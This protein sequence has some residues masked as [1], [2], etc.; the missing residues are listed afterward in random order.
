MNSLG[1][2][3]VAGAGSPTGSMSGEKDG[4]ACVFWCVQVRIIIFVAYIDTMYYTSHVFFFTAGSDDT[5]PILGLPRRCPSPPLPRLS[6]PLPLLQR[7]KPL[8]LDQV[9]FLTGVHHLGAAG[10]VGARARRREVLVARKTARLP[11]QLTR[12][13]TSPR[14]DTIN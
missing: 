2:L 5:V 6:R 14:L 10:K 7:M 12:P 13:R 3:V 1:P 11:G 8:Q 4:G 9:I